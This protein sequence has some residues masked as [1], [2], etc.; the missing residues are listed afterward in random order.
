MLLV[1]TIVSRLLSVR[2][3]PPRFIV[4]GSE[5]VVIVSQDFAFVN[6]LRFTM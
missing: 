5:H 4:L 1:I 2:R 3:N 6:T